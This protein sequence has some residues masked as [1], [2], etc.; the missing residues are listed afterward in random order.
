MANDI[1]LSVKVL[2]VTSAAILV[3]T[4]MSKESVW[5]PKSQISD[6]TGNKIDYAT[7][8]FIPEWLAVE[9]GLV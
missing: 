1:E 5:I 8:I 3:D 6:Y 7:T 4:E 9:K 2:R